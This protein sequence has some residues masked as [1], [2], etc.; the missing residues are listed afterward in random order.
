M[1]RRTASRATGP[2][3]NSESSDPVLG[4]RETTVVPLSPA[5]PDD[6]EGARSEPPRPSDLQA[7]QLR[8]TASSCYLYGASAGVFPAVEAA[9]YMAYLEQ[10]LKDAGDPRDP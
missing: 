5:R 10:L 2:S 4:P 3:I 1:D 8:E 9:A 6:T 7:R